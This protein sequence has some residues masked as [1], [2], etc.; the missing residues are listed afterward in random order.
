MSL[1]RESEIRKWLDEL[2]AE[3][4]RIP[5]YPRTLLER[6]EWHISACEGSIDWFGHGY[7]ITGSK[8]Y[9]AALDLGNEFMEKALS[10]RAELTP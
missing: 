4:P 10:V 9:K 8:N 7:K 3:D 6:L 5:A 1:E 2:D